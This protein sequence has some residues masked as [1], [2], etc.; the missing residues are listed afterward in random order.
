MT[1]TSPLVLDCTDT[2]HYL[3]DGKV[4]ASGSHHELLGTTPG[5]RALVA[6]DTE[7][8]VR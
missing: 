8:T 6:R 2:V 3:V 5:Y 4:A 7:E 1:T